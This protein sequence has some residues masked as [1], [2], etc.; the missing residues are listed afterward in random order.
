MGKKPVVISPMY[1]VTPTYI[2]K[3]EKYIRMKGKSYFG[4]GDLTFSAM[5]AYRN[6]GAVPEAVYSGRK[7]SG[8]EFNHGKWIIS[9]LIGS[10]IMSVPAGGR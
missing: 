9:C 4:P 5:H 3:A 2:D 7:E 8:S 10:N 1:F 6:F